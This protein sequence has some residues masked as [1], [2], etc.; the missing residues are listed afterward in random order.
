[1]IVV[2]KQD[3]DESDIARVNSKLVSLG[4]QTQVTVGSNETIIGLIGNTSVINEEEIKGD[5]SV[6]DVIK[7]KEPF[8]KANRKFH[9]D[10]TII[11]I[12][13]RKIGGEKLAIIAGPCSV[14][15][16]EQIISVAKSVKD[17]GAGF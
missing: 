13:G 2:L 1:M 15:S 16:P 17:S 7:V 9:P 6:E 11:D 12:C 4:L 14:E 5:K 10:N 3:S 8:K